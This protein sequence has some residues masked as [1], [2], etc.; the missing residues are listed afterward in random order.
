MHD[1]HIHHQKSF[2]LKDKDMF[3]YQRQGLGLAFE[4]SYIQQI[5][6]ANSCSWRIIELKTTAS[7]SVGKL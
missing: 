6:I 5:H 1:A 4:A 3:H 7:T 2:F